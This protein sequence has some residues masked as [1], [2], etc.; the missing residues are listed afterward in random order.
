[1]EYDLL[2]KKFIPNLWLAAQAEIE[3]LRF[4]DQL[5]RHAHGSETNDDLSK[6]LYIL[7]S[8][9]PLLLQGSESEHVRAV[10]GAVHTIQKLSRT[11]EEIEP[12]ILTLR[13]GDE[14]TYREIYEALRRFEV[15]LHQI[16]ANTMLK[17]EEFA[18][19]Q[20]SDIRSVYWEV[21]WGFAAIVLSAVVLLA[22]LFRAFRSTTDLLGAAH[23]AEA[24]ATAA[25]AQ[26]AAVID[27]VPARISARDAHGREVLRNRYEAD[28]APKD[29]GVT[30]QEPGTASAL[31][32]L[33]RQVFTTG[34]PVPLFE[35]MRAHG[36]V[37]RGTWL[38]TKAP[39][40]DATG[41]TINVVTVSLDISELKEAQERHTLL[42]TA[43]EYAGDA[44]EIT[45]AASRFKYV[46]PAFEKISGYAAHEAVGETPFSLLMSGKDD[47]PYYRSVQDIIASGKIWHGVLT[48]R[49]KDGRLYQQETTISP[50]CDAAGEINHYVAVKRDITERLRA[51]EQIWHLAHH[52]ALT[53]L[54]NRLLFQDRLRQAIVHAERGGQPGALLFVD[55]DKF[56]DVNDTLGHQSGDQ[57]LKM[58]TE[59]LRR[60]TREVD[61]VARLG[62]DEFAIILANLTDAEGATELAQ[63]LLEELSA[64]FQLDRQDILISASIGITVFPLDDD[65]IHK[66]LRNADLAMYRAKAVGRANYQFFSRGMD[67]MFQRRKAL[68]RDLGHM[69]EYGELELFYQPQVDAQNGMLVGAEA[70]LRWTHPERGSVS[71]AEFIP[72][73]EESGLIVPL[74]KW[75]LQAACTQNKAWQERGLPAICMAVNLSAAQFHRRDFVADVCK[76]LNDS[77]LK[78]QYLELEITEAPLMRDTE[79]T[80]A[81][82][83]R[84]TDLGIRIALD[85]FDTGY[86]SMS[87]LKRFPVQKLKIDQT[88]VVGVTSDRGD[89]AIVRAV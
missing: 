26:L 28:L 15:P 59:R 20:R 68:E 6:R 33:D 82:L 54:P 73:A 39:L 52:D 67:V 12:A 18:A 8:R 87:Y 2:T 77:G 38:T 81:I 83:R 56:K 19:A 61:T 71:P 69:L 85:D 72:L 37:R 29:S 35:E 45:D 17:D 75:V 63:R 74:G 79:A 44:I 51:Q 88:F 13:R 86:S 5:G 50:V 70:L 43:V 55:L 89:A 42:A 53:E 30:T 65:D 11:L 4:V 16:V 47:E 9:L 62:G 48:A 14:A 36:T 31:D 22:L 3:F 32:V 1:M 21:L 7:W 66:L 58:V 40:R 24:T 46:N 49:R 57:L 78:P 84:L 10:D 34:E 76:V 41:R 64:P 23:A 27:A 60:S 80:I 25:R